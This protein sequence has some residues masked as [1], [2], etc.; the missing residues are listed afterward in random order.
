MPSRFLPIAL[1]CVAMVAPAS[2]RADAI[3]DLERQQQRLF[4][5]VAPS[6]VFIATPSSLGTGFFVSNDGLILSNA[7]VVGEEKVVTVL[8]QDGRKVEGKVEAIAPDGLDLALVKVAVTGTRPLTISSGSLQVGSWV[9]SIGHGLG[10]AWTFT[11]GMVSNIYP[12]G[13]ERPVFQ[14]QIPLNPG[15]SGGP[16]V[17]RHGKLVGVVTA[18]VERSN[19]VN[20]A[21]RADIALRVFPALATD[22]DCLVIQLPSGVPVF[23]DGTLAGKGPRIVVPTSERRTFRVQAALQGAMREYLVSWPD[24][25]TLTIE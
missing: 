23:I 11:T 7:H 22:C 21:I 19:D 18:G 5:Q 20:F 17:D 8:L 3:E 24:Q 9:A 10:G 15:N 25:R 13:A 6:V 1:A 2:S 4:L 14:T 12:L 16:V